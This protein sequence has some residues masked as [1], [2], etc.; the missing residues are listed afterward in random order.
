MKSQKGTFYLSVRFGLPCGRSEDSSPK[1]AAVLVCR[2]GL[3]GPAATAS[4]HGLPPSASVGNGTSRGF[5]LRRKSF[6]AE[7]TY[8]KS[9]PAHFGPPSIEL[10]ALRS[11]SR[12]QSRINSPTISILA[13][14]GDRTRLSEKSRPNARHTTR[15]MPTAKGTNQCTMRNLMSVQNAVGR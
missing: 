4:E 1:A 13:D 3:R 2:A 15:G 8:M 11:N 14:T 10:R 7:R 5:A 9:P 12:S 6:P